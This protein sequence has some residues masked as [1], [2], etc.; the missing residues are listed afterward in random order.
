M[1]HPAD[2]NRI[3]EL[4]DNLH[5]WPLL[6]NLVHGQLY[7]HCIEWNESP[8]DAILKVQQKLFNTGLT[9]FDPENQLEASRE[10]AVRASITASLELLTKSEKI[11]LFYI[12]SSIIGFGIYTYRDILSAVVQMDPKQFDKHT[13][14]LWCHGLISFE[15]VIFPNTITKVS[16]IGIHEVIA[17]FIN[18]NFSDNFY[19]RVV[20]INVT[21]IFNLLF[22]YFRMN[23]A[24]NVGQLFLSH[25][26]VVFIPFVIRVLYILA[27]CV[28][29]LFFNKLNE[30]VGQSIQLLQNK[31]LK[32]FICNDQFPPVKNMH[33]IIEQDCKSIHSLLADG[34]YGEALAWMKDYFDNHPCR[35][36]IET[37]ITNL[38]LLLDSSNCNYAVT[39]VIEDNLSVFKDLLENLNEL[40][41]ITMLNIIGYNHVLY[42]INATNSGDVMHYLK[43]SRLY[44]SSR[45]ET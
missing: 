29:I 35:L 31:H 19:L 13:K 43:C 11:L 33:K 24:T 23:I 45:D 40:Q 15:D 27:K 16:F 36:S 14:S 37:V 9:A 41:R 22:E 18:E 30:I 38:N 7:V 28:Q 5:C 3:E 32:K 10:N 6:L 1:L 21:K 34:K 2:V 8:K 17:H 20:N 25:C 12:A 4:A 42:L 44:T 39:L 26:D